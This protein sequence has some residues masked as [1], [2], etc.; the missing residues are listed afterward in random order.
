MPAE[1]QRHAEVL[2][3]E[4]RLVVVDI[5]GG[6]VDWVA[7]IIRRVID[8]NRELQNRRRHAPP[9][10]A[11][12]IRTQRLAAHG[13]VDDEADRPAVARISRIGRHNLQCVAHALPLP[14]GR[15]AA[16]GKL[17]FWHK[18]R[19]G[20]SRVIGQARQ[21]I[22]HG[23]GDGRANLDPH[24]REQAGDAAD[25]GRIDLD[26]AANSARGRRQLKCLDRRHA[27]EVGQFLE[28]EALER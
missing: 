1:G 26:Q 24:A 12:A 3:L 21:T 28:H 10:R 15:T 17:C 16:H 18:G 6:D 22:F 7:E 2:D 19:E 5:A 20:D 9:R 13:A 14:A 11:A 27:L 4:I 23:V 25:V 8:G